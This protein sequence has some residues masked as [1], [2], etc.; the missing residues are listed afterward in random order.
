MRHLQPVLWSKGVL[1]SPQHLQAQDR[2]HEEVLAF[3]VGALAFCP[4]GFARLAFDHEALS[5]GTLAVS[6]V[7]G[8]FPDGLLFDAPGGGA[9]PAARQVADA[10]APDQRTLL[11][12][13][14]VPEYRPGA[15]NVARRGDH[16][17]ARWHADEQLMRD[18]TTGLTERPIQVAPPSLRLLLEGESLEGFVT[19]PIARLARATTGELSFDH[20]FIPP[21]LDL[22]ASDTLLG[23]A[24]RLIERLSAKSSSLSGSRRQRNQG[25]ADFS[26]TDV[27][28]FWLL[29]TLNTHFPALRHLHDVRRGHP[30]MLW[31]SM[32]G[33][34]GALSTFAAGADARSLPAYDHLRLGEGFAELERRLYE[35]LDGA[36]VDTAVSL[37]L[38]AIRPTLH[39][40]AIDQAKWLEAPQWFLAV[41]APLRQQELIPKVLQGC[42]VGSADVVDT[43]I[44][45]AL[46]G[47]ELAHV[48]S[49]PAAVPVKLDFQY[50]AIRKAG[51]AWDAINRARN[52]AVYLPAELVDARFELV[53][54]LR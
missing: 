46:P 37:P 13:L 15:R 20:T 34:V 33:L 51:G 2:H 48:S 22:S 19:L 50:F 14:A 36:A 45:Q 30:A 4:W 8:R 41:S 7:S 17:V 44:R 49:P 54:V 52:L 18:E 11:A 31:E 32:L 12:Y 43:L 16:A 28:N 39:A 6:G 10:Y 24:R 42:K 38:K 23:L 40:V 1:L 9:T 26:V 3:Q 25:L 53:I 47:I 27:G 5:A 21:L 35:L 29:Y